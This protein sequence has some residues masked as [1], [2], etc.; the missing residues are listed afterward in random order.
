MTT[1]RF[2]DGIRVKADGD[3]RIITLANKVAIAGHGALIFSG[4]MSARLLSRLKTY[5]RRQQQQEH[6]GTALFLAG[7]R[8]M[9]PSRKRRRG[10]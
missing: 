10:R 8:V 3:Y 7:R 9:A 4:T 5:Q 2:K 6:S 1:M